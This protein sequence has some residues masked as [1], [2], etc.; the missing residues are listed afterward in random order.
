MIPIISADGPTANTVKVLFPVAPVALSIS[1]K[2]ASGLPVALAALVEIPVGPVIPAAVVPWPLELAGMGLPL[3]SIEALLKNNPTRKR[4]GT[5]PFTVKVKSGCCPA[6]LEVVLARPLCISPPTEVGLSIRVKPLV[7]VVLFVVTSVK[8]PD[9]PVSA[10]KL[11]TYTGIFTKVCTGTPPVPVPLNV[12][13]V[14]GDTFVFSKAVA[15]PP[16]TAANMT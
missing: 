3:E 15:P 5:L 12:K 6:A 10:V 11:V 14:C 2:R 8:F 7:G 13:G 1:K 16:G 9:D 4:L